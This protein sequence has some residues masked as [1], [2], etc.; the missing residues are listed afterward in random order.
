MRKAGF[1]SRRSAPGS[2]GRAGQGD[3]RAAPDLGSECPTMGVEGQDA[4]TTMRTSVAVRR[5]RT[6]KSHRF[7]YCGLSERFCR[8]SIIRE[9]G[10]L[11]EA[12]AL[13]ARLGRRARGRRS[14]KGACRPRQ[15]PRCG[16]CRPPTPRLDDPAQF[17]LRSGPPLREPSSG[18][19][20]P[21]LRRQGRRRHR[22]GGR[23]N[24]ARQLSDDRKS[25][26][27]SQP[28]GSDDQT[29]DDLRMGAPK[30]ASNH[31]CEGGRA[32]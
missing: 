31:I 4:T 9:V 14:Y 18:R 21:S 2:S 26:R 11:I 1:T 25:A 12:V 3:R 5:L 30:S 16:R 17:R 27:I 22:C 6:T 15:R 24:A 32:G 8:P 29:G 19:D 10:L 7:P 13:L 23:R 28:P 20:S